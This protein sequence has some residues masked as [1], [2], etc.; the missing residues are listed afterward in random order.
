MIDSDECPEATMCEAHGCGCTHGY[1][2]VD[3]AA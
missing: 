3:T 2:T 1:V